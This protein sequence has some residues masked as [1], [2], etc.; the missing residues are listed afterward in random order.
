MGGG[1]IGPHFF[2]AAG[3]CIYGYVSDRF[4]CRVVC[5]F[6]SVGG[7]G[8]FVGKQPP[9]LL[10]VCTTSAATAARAAG[11]AATATLLL[12]L[13]GKEEGRKSDR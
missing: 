12:L 3:L 9:C 4:C 8:K 1:V 6:F 5:A 10:V 2:G 11:T 7:V 13:W